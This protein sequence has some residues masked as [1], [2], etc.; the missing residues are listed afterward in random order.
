M[1]YFYIIEQHVDG[2]WWYH[3]RINPNKSREEAE[4]SFKK[5]FFWDLERT[6]KIIETTTLLP[7]KT[8]VSWD[9]VTWLNPGGFDKY[10]VELL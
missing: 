8:L 9:C 10:E 4:E 2:S 1:T 5:E 6:H 7:D 3:N